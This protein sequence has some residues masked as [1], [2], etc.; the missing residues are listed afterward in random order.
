MSKTVKIGD[1][2]EIISTGKSE[3]LGEKGSK[4][5]VHSIHAQTLKEKGYATIG[6][7]KPKEARIDAKDGLKM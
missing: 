2:V 3:H 7:S 4:H 1:L 6:E 5:T